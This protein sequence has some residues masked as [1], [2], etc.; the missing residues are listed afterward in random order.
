MTISFLSSKRMVRSMKLIFIY[1]PP[2]VGKLTVAK[3][4]EA[5]TKIPLADN[6]SLLNPVA[7]VFGWDHPERERLGR[8]FRLEFFQAA[9]RANKSMITTF[10]G[11]GETFDD[12][13]QDVCQIVKVEDGEVAFVRLT[14]PKEVL[15]ER[16]RHD[17][18]EHHAKMR[19]VEELEAKMQRT[20]DICAKILV[21]EHLEMDSSEHTPD[22]MARMIKE[23]Y[24]L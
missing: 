12:F 3:A 21:G 22:H 4:L 23:Y 10:G 14:A 18:R 13:I 2:A 19:T 16:V 24:Q 5:L 7:K 11:G 1:G 9:A 8:S 15:F 20:P 6:H 17:S